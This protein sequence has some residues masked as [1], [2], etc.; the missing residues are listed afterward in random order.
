[1]EELY[2]RYNPWWEDE[3]K[4][5][6]YKERPVVFSALKKDLESKSIV[7]L[8]GLRRVGKTTL[9][10]RLIQYLLSQKVSP[11]HIFYMSMDDYTLSSKS[12]LSLI[13]EYRTLQKLSYQES[14]YVFL[15]E[16][17]YQKGFERQLKN[18][19]DQ[20]LVKI[21]ASSSS[22]TLLR[23]R[24][25][26]LTGRHITREIQPLNFSE[27]LTFKDIV[28]KKSD[29]HLLHTYF[30]DYLQTGGMPEYV[31]EKNVEYLRQLVD[32]I[33]YKDIAAHYNITNTQ[34]LKDFFL[35]LMERAGKIVSI[36][37]LAHILEI[38]PD[39]AKRYL[40]MFTDTYLIYLVPRYGKTSS[41]VRA[42]KKLYA[43]DLGIRTFFT[44]F[45]D[46][47]SLF[48]NYVF[49][50]LKQKNLRYVYEEGIELDFMT[51]DK[52][53]IEIKYGTELTEKQKKL[54]NSFPA[55]KKTIISSVEEVEKY[56]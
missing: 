35:L 51:E 7:F 36:N 5:S 41:L 28:L 43:A 53:L 21:V 52:E 14:V 31:L 32:D 44:G 18:I 49:L 16:I 1:M 22:A 6:V 9:M 39:T 12:I 33:L 26:F 47:G 34:L 29:S 40:Q 23:N 11:R 15:D 4:F 2:Y 50:K 42:P 27:Y 8:T 38:S 13:E 55:I 25:S 30:E 45:R 3:Y 54:F 17:T 46:K 56:K 20:Q 19:Y 10:K 24:A 48:E 37:K